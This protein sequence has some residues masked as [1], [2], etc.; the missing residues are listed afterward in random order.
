MPS[1]S[2]E[3][4][5][6]LLAGDDDDVLLV[7]E[8][9]GKVAN[10]SRKKVTFQQSSLRLSSTTRHATSSN[11]R[12]L[13]SVNSAGLVGG[14]STSAAN[15]VIRFINRSGDGR[16]EGMEK[17]RVGETV[18]QQFRLRSIMAGTHHP[19]PSIYLRRPFR[20]VPLLQH[21]GEVDDGARNPHGGHSWPVDGEW[22]TRPISL[23]G[24]LSLIC[25][26][27]GTLLLDTTAYLA[28]PPGREPRNV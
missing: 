2:S 11:R 12:H 23:L 25:T 22:M 5:E 6:P 13:S 1:I 10:E 9:S 17:K 16:N 27:D 18:R 4:T 19:P 26:H 14:G 8:E 3:A 20:D 15:E 7:A 21:D 24:V 28:P